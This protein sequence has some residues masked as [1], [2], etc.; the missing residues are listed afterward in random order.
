M[1]Q[2]PSAKSDL[3][4]ITLGSLMLLGYCCVA[5]FSPA[6]HAQNELLPPPPTLLT[7][8]SGGTDND[9]PWVKNHEPVPSEALYSESNPAPVKS[10][11]KQSWHNKILFPS[12]ECPYCGRRVPTQEN[13]YL[14]LVIG[15]LGQIG[16]TGRFFVQW[17]ASEKARASVIPESFWWIS[18][19]GSVFL[20]IYAISILAWPIILGQSPNIFIYSRN[21]YFIHTHKKMKAE[22]NAGA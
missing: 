1:S 6:A 13:S 16:F 3:L 19:L 12:V 15:F 14:W 20:L 7:G 18:I 4:A 22:E 21:L 2:L 5:L 10:E 11:K 17:L 8:G 9:Y